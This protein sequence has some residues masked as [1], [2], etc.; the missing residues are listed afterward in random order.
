VAKVAHL[1]T[2]ARVQV[3]DQRSTEFVL[4]PFVHPSSP[5]HLVGRPR[6][7]GTQADDAARGLNRRSR[8]DRRSRT[9]RV[10]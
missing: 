5:I 4:L 9:L 10:A 2:P 3:R 6:D 8:R 7:V 1:R